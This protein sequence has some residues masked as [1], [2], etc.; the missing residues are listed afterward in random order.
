MDS[1]PAFVCNMRAP[2]K[3]VKDRSYRREE[4]SKIYGRDWKEVT[5]YIN[6]RQQIALK[7]TW[8][9]HSPL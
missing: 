4:C 1:L 6:E 8:H 7:V 3:P 5:D 2:P 9:I